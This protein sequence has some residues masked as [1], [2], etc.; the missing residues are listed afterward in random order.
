MRANRLAYRLP[1]RGLYET[2]SPGRAFKYEK[3]E[4]RMRF[5]RRVTWADFTNAARDRCAHT[6]GSGA[7]GRWLH[8]IVGEG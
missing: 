4:L 3:G 2:I 8:V 6:P 1:L 7:L 5:S